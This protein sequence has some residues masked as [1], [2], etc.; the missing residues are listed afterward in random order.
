MADNR[1]TPFDQVEVQ[2]TVIIHE[3]Y[4]C[5]YTQTRHIIVHAHTHTRHT[6]YLRM[7]TFLFLPSFLLGHRT[8]IEC[9]FSY[10]VL[11][12]HLQNMALLEH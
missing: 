5:V 12:Y 4:M 8:W 11:C 9:H 2:P 1:N 3:V 7:F 6:T 10:S